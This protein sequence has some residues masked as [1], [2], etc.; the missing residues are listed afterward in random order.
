MFNL[1]IIKT[2]LKLTYYE[3]SVLIPAIKKVYPRDNALDVFEQKLKECK[4]DPNS[5]AFVAW[6][7]DVIK[8]SANPLIRF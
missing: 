6:K 3:K 4:N 1:L 8:R 5:H 2:M 7:K